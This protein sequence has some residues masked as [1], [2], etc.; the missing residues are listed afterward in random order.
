[1]SLLEK[2]A[3]LKMKTREFGR[4]WMELARNLIVVSALLAFADKT[5]DWAVLMFASVTVFVFFFYYLTYF[6][7]DLRPIKPSWAQLG[8]V[9]LYGGG[10]TIL[11][12][13]FA[14][15]YVTFVAAMAPWLQIHTG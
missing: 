6:L 14:K 2:A 7:I 10:A 12:Y 3:G 4:W 5:H 1:M 9:L 13:S 11:A 8:L 15:L